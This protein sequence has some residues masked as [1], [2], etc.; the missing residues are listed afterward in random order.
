MNFQVILVGIETNSDDSDF[1]L[2]MV[3]HFAQ[4]KQLQLVTC[5]ATDKV[6]VQ[7][8]FRILVEK[9]MKSLESD[10]V[11]GKGSPAA[12]CCTI[13]PPLSPFLPQWTV[14]VSMITR[15]LQDNLVVNVRCVRVT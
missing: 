15:L 9:I 13:V 11:A 3:R 2:A 7:E 10:Q 1:N 14:F 6:K 8:V 5:N 12:T 4:E